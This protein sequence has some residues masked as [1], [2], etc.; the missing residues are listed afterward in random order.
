M[1]GS[2]DRIRILLLEDSPLDAELTERH[3]RR[4]GLDPSITRVW[5]ERD[6]R[7]EV[8]SSSHEVIIADYHLPDFNGMKALEI[9]REL[10]PDLPF[11]FMS[12]S[13][14][15]ERAVQ[16]LKN[17]ATDYIIKDR[18]NRIGAAVRTALKQR[19]EM[20]A[21]A[22]MQE[23]LIESERRFQ[24]VVDATRNVIWDWSVGDLRV[25]VN[26]AL[27]DEWGYE[28][29]NPH[30]D[31][32]MWAGNIHPDDAGWV[33]SSLERALQ[34]ADI[35]WSAEYRFRRA[36]RGYGFVYDRRIIIRDETGRAVRVIG[37]MENI[38]SRKTFELRATDAE[39]LAHIGHFVTNRITGRRE[40]SAE[41][42]RIF[43]FGEQETITDEMLFNRV[44]PE[45]RGKF[46]KSHFSPAAAQEIE[47]RILNAEGR[48]RMLHTR[49]VAELD[50][51]GTLLRVFGTVQD[52]TNRV[53]SEQ[54]IR[55]LSRINT[56]ILSHAAEGIVAVGE[57]GDLL[58]ANPAAKQMLGWTEDV[59]VADV[60][61]LLHPGEE[62]GAACELFAD[63]QSVDSRASESVFATAS[64]QR[65]DV[66]YTSSAIVENGQRTGSVIT[67]ADITERKR[68][69][70]QLEQ[71]QRVSALGH[72][73]AT[74]AHEFNNVLM[75]IQPFTE[76]I[77]RRSED[78]KVQSAA[79]QIATS[80]TRGRRVTEEILRFTQPAQPALQV[81]AVGD[82]LRHLLPELKSL[83][84]SGIEIVIRVPST[85]LAIACDPAQLQ[86]VLTNLVL[87]ARDAIG[88][89]G[90]ITIVVRREENVVQ[91]QVRDTGSGMP[92][93]I[94]RHVFDPLFTTKRTG[95]GLGL[96][97]AQRVVDA[98][99][100]SIRAESMPGEGTMFEITLPAAAVA[101]IP[102]TDRKPAPR[103]AVQR[104]VLVEDDKA[105]AAGITLL[106]ESAGVAVKAVELGSQAMPAIR[107]FRPDVV[108]LDMS[109]PDME[110]TV[111]Y[112]LIS[113]ACPALPVLFSS[114]HGD[115]S[116]VERFVGRG[117][118]GFLRK[119]YDFD[120]LLEAI[121]RVVEESAEKAAQKSGTQS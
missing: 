78:P 81:L 24:Y 101:H 121:E 29:E 59:P 39:R 117:H 84:C 26:D 21:R 90:V 44:H 35:R 4:E 106:L 47:F 74:I 76:L 13:L 63:L 14:G 15:E 86:Q 46:L 104:V 109:L 17:G 92:E 98:H 120:E 77:R 99:G 12:G 102:Q 66:R 87:N 88:D 11:I 43:G 82:W 25:W 36:D 48:V 3:L 73:A 67:F 68:L 1:T 20:A 114:G 50:S 16:A 65:L 23:A 116:S 27:R 51:D 80:V 89:R 93:H 105:I 6:F 38:T 54:R 37:A 70:T 79:S 110:G 72:V 28:F 97:V 31:Y 33:L 111:V 42:R 94:L 108:V 85:P 7:R 8:V 45:D 115:H 30:L 5:D 9:A 10:A 58:F 18:P 34:S 69:E 103:V 107:E 96:A 32:E 119:P 2:P 60:H 118:V 40:W 57:R 100:G 41:L 22:R 56:M 113:S 62:K 52:I 64:G 75:G 91:L 49:I 71:A 95:T 19:A 55:D 83:V 112:E 53:E 61:A